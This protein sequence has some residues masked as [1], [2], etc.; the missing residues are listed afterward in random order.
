MGY[1]ERWVAGVRWAVGD[2]RW[3][4]VGSWRWPLGGGRWVGGGRLWAVGGG[5]WA[6]IYRPAVSV[7]RV[8]L[9]VVGWRWAGARRVVGGRWADVRWAPIATV[10]L[11]LKESVEY[12][13]S[14]SRRKFETRRRCSAVCSA[15]FRG[16]RRCSEALRG[17]LRGGWLSLVVVCGVVCAVVLSGGGDSGGEPLGGGVLSEA[18]RGLPWRHLAP[19]DN[20]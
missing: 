6:A 18:L 8:D 10:Y 2:G 11:I 1:G 20:L 7:G 14:I 3:W 16:A 4:A 15:V 13:T 5:R 9:G 12:F 19:Y 17:S